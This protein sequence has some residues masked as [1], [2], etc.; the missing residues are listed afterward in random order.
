MSGTMI[1]I[2][3][4]AAVMTMLGKEKTATEFGKAEPAI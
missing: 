1:V 4:L 2:L 3:C